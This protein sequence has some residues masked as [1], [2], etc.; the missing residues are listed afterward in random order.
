MNVLFMTLLDFKTIHE[1]GLYQDLMREFEK[2]GHNV[3]IISPIERRKGGKTEIIN[4]G[5]AL[6]L[7]LK[8]GNI[9]KTNIFEKGIS[10]ILIEP[11]FIAGI[12]RYFS[13]IK[14]D[15]IIYST[16]PITFCNAIKYVKRRDNARTYLLLKDIFPLNAVHLN[17]ISN[18]R[19]N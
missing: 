4:D 2:H 5:K 10:T 17:M 14:F 19:L 9:Q 12:K 6:V 3:F 15:F 1:S 13:G 7:K 16:P 18:T 8:I 11:I